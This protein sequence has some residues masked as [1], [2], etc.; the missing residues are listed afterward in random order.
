MPRL[1][2]GI[3][4]AMTASVL[5]KLHSAGV[6]D[7]F[8]FVS[9][10]LDILATKTDVGYRELAAIRRALISEHAAPVIAGSQL[11]DV[12]VAT[13]SIVSLGSGVLDSLL[14]G[15]LFTCEI[16]EVVTDRSVHANSLVMNTVLSVVTSMSK[17]VVFIDTSNHFD[18][19]NLAA[20]MASRNDVDIETALKRVRVIKCFTVLELLGHLSKL[21]EATSQS[22]DPFYSSLKL[23]VI[24]GIVDHIMPSLAHIHNN[25]GCGYVAQLSHQFRLLTTD[26]CYAL[27]LCN[28]NGLVKTSAASKLSLV[29]K[30]WCSIPDTRLE[31]EGIVGENKEQNNTD[32][33]MLSGRVKVT[34]SKSNRLPIAQRVELNVD[35]WGL[36]AGGKELSSN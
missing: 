5:E 7:V 25:Y 24:D 8:D 11:F 21:C 2:A 35:E 9:H 16:T 22:I 14:G 33:R 19:S 31:V 6:V 13:T 23:I 29:G 18:A 30:L 26:F 28:G 36:F 32:S 1:R 17:N 4:S 10:D 3:C 20:M 15:G 34:L 12:V 27:L